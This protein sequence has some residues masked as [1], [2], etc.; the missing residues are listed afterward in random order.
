MMGIALRALLVLVVAGATALAL[1]SPRAASGLGPEQLE[2]WLAEVPAAVWGAWAL[3]GVLAL[4]GIGFLVQ[5]IVLADKRAHGVVPAGWG[6]WRAPAGAA[7]P[8]VVAGPGQMVS[9]GLL[10]PAGVMLLLGG[11]WAA[12]HPKQEPPLEFGLGVTTLMFLPPTV[13]VLLRRRRLGPPLRPDGATA[14]GFGFKFA[15][16]ATLIVVPLQL[17][18]V[19]IAVESG[20]PVQAQEIVQQFVAPAQPWHPWVIAVFGVF[21]APLTE[22]AVFRGLLYPSLRGRT[23]GGPFAAAVVTAV[24]FAAIHNSLMAFVPLLA[25]ALVLCWVMERTNS[26]RACVIVH[27]IYN[28]SS[29][30]PMLIRLIGGGQAS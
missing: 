6:P 11:I 28:A 1:V 26:L 19:V 15:C 20:Q 21:V 23:P 24:I 12:T 29:L 22:E 2:R 4:L 8:T 3:K 7:W 10:F 17:L 30:A 25:L 13:L 14:A 18:W 9:L 5:E 27:A 16:I